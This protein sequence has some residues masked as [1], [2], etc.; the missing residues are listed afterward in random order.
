ML[1]ALV[2]TEELKSTLV[3]VEQLGR[4]KEIAGLASLFDLMHA[5]CPAASN[6]EKHTYNVCDNND[7]LYIW[8]KIETR[9]G[10]QKKDH[11]QT[12]P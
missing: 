7:D 6:L 1:P 9:I 2:R 8:I 10:P 3:I 5:A 12:A 4:P 11:D